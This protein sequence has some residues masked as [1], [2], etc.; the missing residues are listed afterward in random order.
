MSRHSCASQHSA[1]VVAG[2]VAVAASALASLASAQAPIPAGDWPM[3]S[4]DLAGTRFSP[5][6]GIDAGNVGELELSWSVPVARS[7]DDDDDAGGPAGNPQ[8]TPIVVAGVMYLPVRGHEVL[9]L[10][11]ATGEELWRTALPAPEGTEARGVAYWPGDADLG[12]RIL[13]MAGPTLIALE[14]ADGALVEDFGRNGVAQVVVPWRGVPLI[15]GNLAILGTRTGE[16]NRGMPGDTRAFD[17]RTGTLAWAFH[18]VPLPGE[19]GHETWLDTGWRNRSGA[20]VWAYYMTLDADRNL[21]YMPVSSAAGNY[22][23]GDRPGDN[24]FSNSVVAVDA[25]TGEYRWHFQ[26]VHHDL[27]DLDQPNPPVLVDIERDG[28]S[29]PALALVGKSSWV[30]ILN[31]E[32]GQPIFGVEER[33]VPAGTVPDE[34]YSPTQPFPVKPA[35]PLSRVAFDRERDMVRPEDTTPQHAAACEELWARSGGF[36]NAGPYTPFVFHEA[37]APPRSTLQ[38]PG[39]LGGVNWGGLAADPTRGLVFMHVNDS[40]LVGWIEDKTPGANYGNG[41]EGS[42]LPYDR[43]SVDGHGPYFTF[44][45]P[46]ID[47]NG[48]RHGSL[49]CYRPPW[50]RLVALDA[51]SGEVAWQ[52]TL[53]ITEEL[54]P[55][56]QL[57]GST[58]SA[59]PS[60]TASGLVFVGATSDRR[61][62]AFDARTGEQL[63][64]DVL[65]DN[66]NANVVTYLGRDGRQYVAAVAGDTLV[67]Y[68][69]R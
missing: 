4:R 12:P 40:S 65:E 58:G 50:S 59:G 41:T 64:E 28:R 21:L 44:T 11:A 48:E 33:P 31:R 18:T 56:R 35:E 62:R 46:L 54:P 25:Q 26:T 51:N 66:V 34:W 55:D 53:G 60:V 1:P 16:V 39:A 49:P 20:N 68:S 42:T 24:L 67:A 32:T 30:Y 8:A 5:L 37:G 69:L 63:W 22:W 2:A 52:T 43:G 6:T 57:T 10:D 17:V 23:G 14:A 47:E 19:V 15:Y 13:I 38:L 45:A 7:P 36:I 61:L 27:W 29:V 9:A 3:Y